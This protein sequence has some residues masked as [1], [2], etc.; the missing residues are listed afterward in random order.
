MSRSCI[1][2][3]L[4]RCDEETRHFALPAL[5]YAATDLQPVLSAE[6]LR[7][8]HGRHHARYVETLNR[9]LS[10]ENFTAR[11]LE[12]ILRI[13]HASGARALFDNAAQAWNHSFFWASMSPAPAEPGSLIASAMIL[14]FGGIDVLRDRFIGE[15]AR[16][17]GSGWVWLVSRGGKLDVVSTHDAGSP[18]LDEDTTPLLACDLWEHA[19][20]LDYRQD[21]G[22]WLAAWWD[23]LANWQLAEAQFAASL[24][25][26]DPWRHPPLG[27]PGAR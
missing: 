8:H 19:Y 4:A 3:T 9:L 24:G 16:H 23:R 27:S 6:T 20:Y 21:R 13:A 14:T 10:E 18:V 7:I 26:G 5:P 15:G 17:F 2:A 22:K 11:T 25:H 12:D 1:D